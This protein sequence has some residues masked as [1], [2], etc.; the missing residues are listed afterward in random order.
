MNESKYGAKK[1][2]EKWYIWFFIHSNFRVAYLQKITF[3]FWPCQQPKVIK[4]N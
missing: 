1:K 3:K 2:R 4:I